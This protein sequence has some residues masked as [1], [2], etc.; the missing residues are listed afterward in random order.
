MT[1]N[2]HYPAEDGETLWRD[3][4]YMIIETTGFIGEPEITEV[5]F[6]MSDHDWRILENFKCWKQVDNILR[7]RKKGMPMAEQVQLTKDDVSAIFY[8]E[9]FTLLKTLGGQS[10]R[11]RRLALRKGWRKCLMS[12]WPSDSSEAEAIIIRKRPPNDLLSICHH[13]K[14]AEDTDDDA[15]IICRK[16]GGTRW[17]DY[18][19]NEFI[20]VCEKGGDDMVVKF[21]SL[22]PEGQTYYEL[23]TAEGHEKAA[24]VLRDLKGLTVSEADMVLKYAAEVFKLSVVS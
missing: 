18:A 13:C 16:R 22:T 11:N 14:F 17:R 5:R 15:V 8:Q 2:Y 12:S 24:A 1:Q 3:Y 4:D 20:C 21:S 7:Q 10:K 9:L 6:R 23:L 19:C